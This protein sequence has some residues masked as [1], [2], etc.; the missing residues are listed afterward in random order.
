MYYAQFDSGSDIHLE[1]TDRGWL[2]SMCKLQG[3]DD[4]GMHDDAELR[5]L[6]G[7]WDHLQ[8]HIAAGHLVHE[9]TTI[10]VRREL[11]EQRVPIREFTEEVF[12]ETQSK[13]PRK[14]VT[15]KKK[16]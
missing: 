16:K 5:T 8:S 11:E 15:L 13:A 1:A 3:T 9:S 12:E 4:L 2:C 7:V 10:R 14:K 6:K